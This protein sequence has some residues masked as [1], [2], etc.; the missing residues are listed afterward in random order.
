MEHSK[1]R[2]WLFVVLIIVLILACGGLVYNIQDHNNKEGN[3]FDDIFNSSNISVNRFNFSF[4]NKK[5]KQKKFFV[6]NLLDDVINSN[7]KNQD[8]KIEIVFEGENTSDTFKIKDIRNKITNLATEEFDITLDYDSK[9]YINK[10]IIEKMDISVD[11]FNQQFFIYKNSSQ[12]GVLVKNTLDAV[13]DSN[14]KYENHQITITIEGVTSADSATITNIKNSID[15]FTTYN[16]SYQYDQ[17]G[18]IN[19][20]LF[21]K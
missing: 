3:I 16:V 14:R 10:I 18:Y 11:D 21:Q 12:M 20:V 9:G 15:D 13:I 5:G 19:Q 17:T 2:K 1:E 7:N 4:E 8:K 6:E